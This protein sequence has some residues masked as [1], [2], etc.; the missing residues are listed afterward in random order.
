M[1]SQVVNLVYHYF[2]FFN[3]SP[4]KKEVQFIIMF[5]YNKYNDLEQTLRLTV[6]K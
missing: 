6:L 1:I 5:I 4:N 2:T 3:Q